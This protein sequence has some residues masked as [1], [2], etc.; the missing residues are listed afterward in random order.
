MRPIKIA[1]L[2]SVGMVKDTAPEDLPPEAFSDVINARFN[3]QGAVA[4]SGHRTIFTAAGDQLYWVKAFPPVSAPI[5]VYGT[6]SGLWAYDGLHKEITRESAPYSF[7]DYYRWQ[8]EIFNG[9][10]IFNNGLD[11]PQVWPAFNPDFRAFDLPYWPSSLRARW[12]RSFGNFLIA[13]WMVEDGSDRPFRVRWSSS[14]KPGQV[15][16]SWA[17]DDPSQ[18]SGEFDIAE[19]PD[20][21][22][23][24][25]PLGDLFLV[26]KERSIYGMQYVGGQFIFRKFRIPIDKGLLYRDCVQAFP[27]GHFVVGQDDIYIHYGQAGSDR[28]VV[29]D[30]LRRWVFNQL[31]SS[32]FH[33]CFTVVN[34]TNSEVWFCFPE[35]KETY[36]SLALVWNWTTG[37]VGIR[38]L[39]GTPFMSTGVVDQDS[40]QDTWGG[41]EVSG[42]GELLSD[43]A[44]V[45]TVITNNR[46]GLGA[47]EAQAASLSA[48]GQPVQPGWP[49]FG[50]DPNFRYF[51]TVSESGGPISLSEIS[52]TNLGGQPIPVGNI[53][54][55]VTLTFNP[56][57]VRTGDFYGDPQGRQAALYLDKLNPYSI[58]VLNIAGATIKGGLGIDEPSF[59]AIVCPVPFYLKVNDGVVEGG[60]APGG[61]LTAGYWL[62]CPPGGEE[63][64]QDSTTA[65]GTQNPGELEAQLSES[66]ITSYVENGT[67]EVGTVS[68]T[69]GGAASN[70]TPQLLIVRQSGDSSILAE[71]LK[72]T[73]TP[74]PGGA[75]QIK[76][77]STG[78]NRRREA[79]FYIYV[80]DAFHRQVLAGILPVSV[81][82][83][84]EEYGLTLDPT[85]VNQFVQLP[86]KDNANATFR[87]LFDAIRLGGTGPFSYNWTT[88][89]GTIVSGQGT[90]EITLDIFSGFL[91]RGASS[92]F[93]GIV[94]CELVDLGNNGDS[95]SKSASVYVLFD[96]S[97][98]LQ[99]HQGTG[100]LLSGN[101]V[102]AGVGTAIL[103]ESL[104][105]GYLA[106]RPSSIVCSATV[107]PSIPLTVSVVPNPISEI[108]TGP[109]NV[110]TS[111]VFTINF[112]A[113]VS[114]G[115]G[116]FTY[117]WGGKLGWTVTN[118]GTATPR[119]SRSLVAA[120]GTEVSYNGAVTL[121]VTD[122][123]TTYQYNVN[124]PVQLVLQ[125]YYQPQII[126]SSSASL[127]SQRATLM[128]AAGVTSPS[129]M[130]VQV[131]PGYLTEDVVDSSVWNF[132]YT[133]GAVV[134]GGVGPFT[135]DWSTTVGSLTGT[136]ASRDFSLTLYAAFG[137]YVSQTGTITCTVTDTGR[138]GN[139][140]T[141]TQVSFAFSL[142]NGGLAP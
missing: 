86:A 95:V 60:D 117:D 132:V 123:T 74:P 23:D 96:N 62:V 56:G 106:A 48:V 13:G 40:E 101:A 38:E 111:R 44:I 17:L 113:T 11:V 8:G 39:P 76:F 10:G 28:S 112:T 78:T 102:A 26:Y 136:G 133:L 134:T 90:P 91:A 32:T 61:A 3:R 71:W 50:N 80:M 12:V 73:V 45:S 122:T 34:R 84:T 98:P 83:G 51:G 30:R 53:S 79:V 141:Q 85:G 52:L 139:P 104:G 92:S 107:V 47:I 128:A 9:I 131:L 93:Q 127:A 14:A 58:I 138:V 4:F 15:P 49:E 116:P 72:D 25:L 54:G 142:S 126:L 110:T 137:D 33:N 18:D 135:Y 24:G 87:Q 16:Q 22:V 55:K 119:F 68:V 46:I 97:L 21:L 81:V 20:Y 7:S 114:N 115:V 27:G 130:S 99:S 35:A 29:E 59:P 89:V 88:N 77:T 100:S 66:G 69:I 120:P 129:Q 37:G 70:K 63:L 41:S 124:I 67:V 42:G 75:L 31:S 64:V 105:G 121:L 57:V 94:T 19:T 125:N 36:A 65:G 103:D 140:T 1:N 43:S 82:H 109:G 2:G 118:D 108:A 5:W 6:Q